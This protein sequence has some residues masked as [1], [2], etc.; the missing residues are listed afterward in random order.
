MK[1][2]QEE[3]TKEKE[4]TRPCIE[5][6]NTPEEYRR[7]LNLERQKKK[8][9]KSRKSS[10]GEK[11]V[12]KLSISDGETESGQLPSLLN[13]HNSFQAINSTEEHGKC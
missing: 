1:A 2:Q 6:A 3:L 7:L 4:K 5:I 12:N 8:K 10:E 9:E 11:D 13:N